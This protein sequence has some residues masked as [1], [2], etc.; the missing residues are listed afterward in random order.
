MTSATQK[1]VEGQDRRQHGGR[2]GVRPARAV[3]LVL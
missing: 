3:A 2:L 1:M